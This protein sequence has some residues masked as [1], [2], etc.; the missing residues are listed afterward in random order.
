MILNWNCGYNMQEKNTESVSAKTFP[1]ICFAM[2]G[3]AFRKKNP[4]GPAIFMGKCHL[5]AYKK[6]GYVSGPPQVS[7]H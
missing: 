1:F 2:G 3:L 6:S 4:L 7:C 5:H